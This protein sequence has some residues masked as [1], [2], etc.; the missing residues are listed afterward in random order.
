M[1]V[2]FNGL[3]SGLDTGALID[4]LVAAERTSATVLE[5][6]Q[7]DLTAQKSIVSSLSS[8]LAS[9]G[10][11]AKGMDLVSEVQPRTATASDAKVSV[12]TSSS[13]ATSATDVRVTSLAAAKV[14]Q[15][16]ALA[17]NGAGVLGSGGVTI[18]VGGVAKAVSWTSADSLDAI[19]TRI[20]DAGAGVT[21]SVLHDGTAYRMVLA[22]NQTGTA[23][24]PTFVDNGDTLDFSNAANVKVPEANAALT[25]NGIPITRS[26]N[27]ITDAVPGLT[28]TLNATH[29]V[30]DPTTKVSVAQDHKATT[31]K[32]KALVDSF[33]AVNNALHVQLD[34]TGTKKGSNTLFG[35]STLRQL[36]TQLGSLASSSY[37]SSNLG[38]LGITRDKAGAMTLDETKL[39]AALNANPNALADIFVTNG[40]S[41]QLS[42][43]TDNY[44]RAGDGFFA[45][46]TKSLTDR[47]GALQVQIDRIHRS[48]DAL[49]TRLEKQ[50]GALEQ[51]M[52][53]LQSQSSSMIAMMSR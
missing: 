50:F 2:T 19:A 33:N 23:G 21:A 37:G 12:A 42:T 8:A 40:F 15:S 6:K 51:A 22:A 32:V 28:L 27:T 35:D 34:Y 16:K 43:L 52:S 7:S 53:Q 14:T 5:R 11:L 38:A 49:Q 48:A 9:L 24:A 30:S 41:S 36:Q 45:A 29:A 1:A 39:T 20:N 46:K 18:T 17:T 31:A 3:V 4:G 26:S 10:N 44:T 13:A 25:I 47:H